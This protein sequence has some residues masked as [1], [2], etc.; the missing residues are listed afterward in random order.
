MLHESLVDPG[1]NATPTDPPV[2]PATAS[3]AIRALVH[4]HQ[5]KKLPASAEVSPAHRTGGRVRQESSE[6][7]AP[8]A[9]V[10]KSSAD[11]DVDDNAPTLSP[12]A[13]HR[14]PVNSPSP[15]VLSTAAV[16][17]APSSVSFIFILFYIFFFVCAVCLSY[18]ANFSRH[19][20]F[21]RF[22]L[23]SCQPMHLLGRRAGQMKMSP[24]HPPKRRHCCSA[25]IPGKN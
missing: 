24:I 19:H 2:A 4:Q 7:E 20:I 13:A 3:T 5:A 16:S 14:S 22:V 12:L 10:L 9:K 25:R 15:L 21:L 18:T 11:V 1:G 17:A 23:L 6:S 8:A